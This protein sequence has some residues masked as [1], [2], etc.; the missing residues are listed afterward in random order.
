MSAPATRKVFEIPSD[1]QGMA[2][3]IAVMIV[4]A[5]AGS[6]N[7]EEMELVPFSISLEDGMWQA[8]QRLHR[9]IRRAI[10]ESQEK[11]VL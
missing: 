3:V 10:A 2:I 9:T 6:H 5:N 11:K 1:F 4:N 7:V 8:T